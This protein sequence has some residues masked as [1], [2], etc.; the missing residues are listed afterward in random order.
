MQTWVKPDGMK[1]VSGG[2]PLQMC[3]KIA[4]CRETYSLYCTIIQASL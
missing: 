2:L 3:E 1:N 4:F